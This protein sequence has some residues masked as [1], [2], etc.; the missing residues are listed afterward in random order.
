MGLYTDYLDEITKRKEQG[1]KPKPIDN[2]PLVEQ[3]ILQ[4]EDMSTITDNTCA[5]ESQQKTAAP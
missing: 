5:W 4:I 2:A 1:L 3:L